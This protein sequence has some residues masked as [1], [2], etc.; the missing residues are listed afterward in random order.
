MGFDLLWNMSRKRPKH[1]IFY[2][3]FVGLVDILQIGN[4]YSLCNYF[5]EIKPIGVD[6]DSQPY[7][8]TRF[9]PQ[10]RVPG[11]YHIEDQGNESQSSKEV[12]VIHR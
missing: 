5:Y 6:M 7:L 12:H 11:V 9:R 1:G 2:T 3:Q 10:L 8:T 4:A